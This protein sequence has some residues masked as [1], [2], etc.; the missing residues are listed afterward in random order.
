M[1]LTPLQIKNAKW[2]GRA[3]IR[4]GYHLFTNA[5]TA[6]G[7]LLGGT[8]ANNTLYYHTGLTTQDVNLLFPCVLYFM[9]AF[10]IS[11]VEYNIDWE[12]T[13]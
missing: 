6:I 13:L 12:P 11:F 9:W 2:A 8:L 7:V 3:A 4:K 10:M 5:G 1:T